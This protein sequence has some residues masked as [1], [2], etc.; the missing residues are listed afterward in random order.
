LH[1]SEH[2]GEN[3]DCGP[4]HFAAG[5]LPLFLGYLTGQRAGTR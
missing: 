2:E 5:I 4:Q 1:G 3:E